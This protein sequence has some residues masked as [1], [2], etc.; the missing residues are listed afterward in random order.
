MSDVQ[1][2][3][4]GDIVPTQA[5][6]EE[7]IEGKANVLFADILKHT[8]SSDIVLCN[9]EA[10]LTNCHEKMTKSGPH[11]SAPTSC[12]N[13]IK[14]SGITV[15]GLANNHIRDYGD[16]GVEETIA[17]C[18]NNGIITVGA[19][20]CIDE[21][22]QPV[23]INIKNKTI[24]IL[25]VCDNECSC[26]N[27]TRMGS[28]G[29]DELETMDWISECKTHCD[30]LIILYHSGLEHYQYPSPI[31]QKRCRK[32][33]EKGADYVTCQHS[34]CIGA[35][36]KYLNG[37]ILY[38]QGNT[39]FYRNGKNDMWN[40]GLLIKISIEKTESSVQ[41]LPIIMC[42]GTVSIAND[43]T[44]ERII[45][46]FK[47]RSEQIKSDKFLVEK[48]REWNKERISLYFGIL[49]GFG[50][51][52]SKINKLLGNR[53]GKIIIPEQAKNVIL[54]VIRCESHR[55]SLLEVLKMES[56]D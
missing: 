16:N 31:L 39:L 26:A 52:R 11:L 20:R 48:W 36:E 49:L 22:R 42:E 28:Y 15:A 33:I 40:T 45:K 21:A 54:N 44:G 6:I 7:F 1:I 56:N 5:N 27:E 29:Y 55:E 4:L 2:S 10:P 13:G 9:L 3:I 43:D 51:Y 14:A 34:H 38:G 18:M 35:Y 41:Y 17:V 12:I 8:I 30:Y 50:K 32:M 53:I 19:G 46:S 24:G 37:E 47:N 25:A 23:F